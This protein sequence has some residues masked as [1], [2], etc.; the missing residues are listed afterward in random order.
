MERQAD[1]QTDVEAD[2]QKTT[3]IGKQRQTKQ[4]HASAVSD[5]A[6]GFSAAV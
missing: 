6:T 3:P 1:R 4:K 5:E 2:K